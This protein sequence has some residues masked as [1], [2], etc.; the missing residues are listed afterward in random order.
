MA[1]RATTAIQPPWRMPR[2]DF[3]GHL[4]LPGKGGGRR[5][6]GARGVGSNAPS[7][8][9]VAA[10]DEEGLQLDLTQA[11]HTDGAANLA[12]LAH[13]RKKSA[14]GTCPLASP[15][16]PT[17]LSPLRVPAVPCPLLP[18]LSSPNPTPDPSPNPILPST[19]P[20][21][22]SRTQQV[23]TL[24]GLARRFICPEPLPCRAG[25]KPYCQGQRPCCARRA[26]LS[27]SVRCVRLR[28]PV[29]I[30][31]DGVVGSGDPRDAVVGCLGERH[32]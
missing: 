28:R 15:N 19:H 25:P 27:V 11:C 32:L 30:V 16:A 24:P 12:D 20:S 2:R 22:L 17:S 26:C 3:C 21:S 9:L 5:V 8:R 7:E 4:D 29:L 1:Y 13:S 18:S 31:L 6:D 14:R 23:P 10:G